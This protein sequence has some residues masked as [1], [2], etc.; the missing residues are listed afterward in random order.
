[1]TRWS[2]LIV[3][4]STLFYEGVRCCLN[5]GNIKVVGLA[6][7]LQGALELR[8]MFHP[9]LCLIGPCMEE[10][11]SFAI[12]RA[13]ME[14]VQQPKVVFLTPH[15]DDPIFQ[16]DATHAGAAAWLPHDVSHVECLIGIILLMSGRKFLP[17]EPWLV[18]VHDM[19]L[20]VRE[21]DVLLLI[22]QGKTDPE[23][24]A[25]LTLSLNTVRTHVKSI[26][27][28]LQ[29]NSRAEAVRRARRR[30]LISEKVLSLTE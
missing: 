20:T 10:I 9:N 8:E 6:F 18:H 2:A 7:T 16:L 22:G 21:R 4:S 29:I 3:D 13:L 27:G 28:K 5:D 17:R 24:A 25:V 1:M 14:C 19:E 12:C 11:L 30:G 23:I 15:Y 26:L